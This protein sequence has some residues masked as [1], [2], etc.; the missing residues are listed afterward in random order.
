MTALWA[1]S[2]ILL[3]FAAFESGRNPAPESALPANGWTILFLGASLL[4]LPLALCLPM[5]TIGGWRY[6]RA[7]TLADWRWQAA[8]FGSAAAGYAVEALLILSAV[9]E[10]FPAGLNLPRRGDPGPVELI[11]AFVVAGAAMIVV[12]AVAASASRPGRAG[13]AR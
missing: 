1:L 6:L 3:C 12:L 8:W 10:I 2:S 9:N 13:L 7:T 4:A 5:A 11:A